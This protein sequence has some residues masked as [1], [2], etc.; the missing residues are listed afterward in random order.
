MNINIYEP[1]TLKKDKKDKTIL[2]VVAI[3]FV[4]LI[5]GIA[6]GVLIFYRTPAK[7]VNVSYMLADSSEGTYIKLNV[8]TEGGSILF[9]ACPE[10]NYE[11]YFGFGGGGGGNIWDEIRNREYIKK[12]GP[13]ENGTEVWILIAVDTGYSI[14]WREVTVRINNL[15]ATVQN[16][17]LTIEEVLYTSGIM[18]LNDTVHVSAKI[19]GVTNE[20]NVEIRSMH[21]YRCGS[22]ISGMGMGSGG[23]G[24]MIFKENDTYNAIVGIG[25][26][27]GAVESLNMIPSPYSGILLFRVIAFDENRSTVTPSYELEI[28]G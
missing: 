12:I 14:Q 8:K 19:S 25:Y 6:L 27:N 3:I 18:K 10:Y 5:V 26:V 7:I 2:M 13:F 23:G 1:H 21:C 22:I 9:G 16:K 28:S 4:I 11:S 24:G 17:N 20:T 15:P